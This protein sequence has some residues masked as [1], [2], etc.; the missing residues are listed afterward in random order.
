MKI[1][2]TFYS[3]L[4]QLY[5]PSFRE[6]FAEEMLE[7]FSKMT[8]QTLKKSSLSFFSMLA[9]EI[10]DL[11][12]NIFC[13]HW[14]HILEE[15]QMTQIINPQSRKQEFFALL[16]GLLGGI[17][18]IATTNLTNRGPAIFLPY[19]LLMTGVLITARL[20]RISTFKGRFLLG[21]GAFMC[22]TIILYIYI[23]TVINPDGVRSWAAH[24]SVP[25]IIWEHVWRLGLMLMFGIPVSAIIAQLSS[26]KQD[27]PA[28][29]D[30]I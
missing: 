7:T 17:T 15:L 4:L 11:P 1:A 8:E 28:I 9:W 16:L 6:V 26:P 19:A 25:M 24:I 5:P 30:S 14:I 10:I 27:N 2:I 3:F 29:P 22:A 18:L 23:V 21:I 13:E 20:S 12:I